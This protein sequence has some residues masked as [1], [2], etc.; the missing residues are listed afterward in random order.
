MWPGYAQI[1]LY[2]RICRG[3]DLDLWTIVCRLLVCNIWTQR[4]KHSRENG[5]QAMVKN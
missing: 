4:L 2:Q 1:R 5:P 3:V